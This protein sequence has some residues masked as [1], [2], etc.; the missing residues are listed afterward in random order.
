M[1]LKTELESISRDLQQPWKEHRKKLIQSIY[2]SFPC[3]EIM[4][5]EDLAHDYLAN[6]AEDR[7]FVEYHL[8]G[9]T[10]HDLANNKQ[11]VHWMNYE[12]GSIS[13]KAFAYYL[14]AYMVLMLREFDEPFDYTVGCNEI[15]PGLFFSHND[16]LETAWK[17]L[18]CD[19]QKDVAIFLLLTLENPYYYYY[20]D[21]ED[22]K[23]AISL[24]RRIGLVLGIV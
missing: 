7:I 14:P 22:E 19:Q 23:K 5:R 8:Y 21:Y 24:L 4:A 17:K 12:V 13:N 6:D 9:I 3:E 2:Q 16:N 1:D 18:S 10:W 20:N 11:I 15:M